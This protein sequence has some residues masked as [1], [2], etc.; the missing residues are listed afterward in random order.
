MVDRN[1]I[2]LIL[3]RLH[4]HARRDDSG[5]FG[6]ADVL[7]SLRYSGVASTDMEAGTAAHAYLP[8]LQS[9]QCIEYGNLKDYVLTEKGRRLAES[10]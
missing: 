3:Q 10:A 4:N 8:H 7:E 1:K 5:E 6:M 9:M 2:P